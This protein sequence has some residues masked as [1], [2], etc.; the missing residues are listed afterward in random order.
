MP[1]SASLLPAACGLLPLVP[2]LCLVL[3]LTRRP[4]CP[5]SDSPTC[6]AVPLSSQTEATKIILNYLVNASGGAGERHP[7]NGELRERVL[8]ANPLLEAFGNARTLR[9]DNSSRFGKLV[10]V[11]F[12]IGGGC[13]R[14]GGARIINYLLEKTRLSNPPPGERNF[15]VLYHLLAARQSAPPPQRD[16]GEPIGG[17]LPTALRDAMPWGQPQALSYLRS[18][19]WSLAEAAD[20]AANFAA[21]SSCLEAIGLQADELGDLWSVM[22]AVLLLGDLAFT[23][24]QADGAEGCSPGDEAA[25]AKVAALLGVP[26]ASLG[27]ALVRRRLAVRQQVVYKEQSPSQAK[28]AVDGLARSLYNGIFEWL[29]HRLNATIAAEPAAE[30]SAAPQAATVADRMSSPGDCVSPRSQY[31]DGVRRSALAVLDIYGFEALPTNS[32][33]QLLINFA[34]EKLQRLFNLH[35]FELEQAEYEREAIDWVHVSWKDNQHTLE[36][37]EG[38]PAGRPGILAAL[39]DATWR[40][41]DDDADANLLSQL[42]ATFAGPPPAGKQPKGPRADAACH[43][44]Y[45]K[46]KFGAATCFGVV[47]YAGEVHY[48]VRGFARKNCESLPPDVVDLL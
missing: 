17:A 38:R 18:E 14:I 29:V 11:S 2:R 1:A 30:H 3:F 41:A 20:E 10:E 7:A 44:S 32:F 35:I 15:H 27:D 36:L 13:S 46:P 9:N 8:A 48:D 12:A 34:N 6:I 16:G 39:D 45:V 4:A 40:G 25:L 26:A 37:I 21:T 23:P 28:D 43:A 5:D 33:E 22:G 24:Q 31:A 47:H 42:H 19:G